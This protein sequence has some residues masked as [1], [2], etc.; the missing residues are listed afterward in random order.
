MLIAA[1]APLGESG[2]SV[3]FMV[4]GIASVVSVV[5][6][7]RVY[8][9]THRGV[10]YIFAVSQSLFLVGGVADLFTPTVEA[11]STATVYPGWREPFDFIAYL[12]FIVGSTAMA[13]ARLAHRDRTA[14]LDALIG[15]GGIG[16]LAWAGVMSEY[17]ASDQLTTFG[18]VVGV[19]F[20]M[21]SL[22]LGF[23]I[24]RVAIGPGARPPSYYFLAV[25]ASGAFIAEILLELELT[26]RTLFSGIDYLSLAVSVIAML[27]LASGALHPSMVEL[28]K[29]PVEATP[30]ITT[31]RVALM[32]IAVLIPPALLL[33][34][35]AENTQFETVAIIAVWA[36]LSVMVMV[37]VFALARI[38]ERMA[39]LD[40]VLA[41]AEGELAAAPSRD[42]MF[43]VT[44]GA[45]TQLAS[46]T[47]G[48]TLRAWDEDAQTW[49]TLASTGIVSP[50]SA[51]APL[52][53]GTRS[54]TRNRV[55]VL[56]GLHFE[57]TNAQPALLT[58]ANAS[59]G[60]WLA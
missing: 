47:T 48:V 6:A 58:A 16:A 41:S 59:A 29:P 42:A 12:G 27:M 54:V 37:R 30:N 40:R 35:E 8:Q 39:A 2:I 52:A 23:A 1:L 43:G 53:A 57:L 26:G 13:R 56:T 15:M 14:T 11:G 31:R 7:T 51:D 24:A 33:R 38:R 3:A 20:T 50:A 25:G 22:T 18:K 60:Q 21:V 17:L 4:I 44:A 46:Q 45:A 55:A 5:Q 9:P 36:V 19:M 28:T 34:E 10:W 32:T 49:E